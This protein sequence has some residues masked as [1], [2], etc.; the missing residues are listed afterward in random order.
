M[1]NQSNRRVLIQKP[2]LDTC[3]TALILGV[4]EKDEITVLRGRAPDSDLNDPNVYCIESGGSGQVHLNNYDHHDPKQYFPPACRQV[5]DASH[6]FSEK[7][8]RLVEY[9]CMVDERINEHHPVPFPSLSNIFSGMLFSE[10]ILLRQ[11]FAGIQILRVVIDDA[12]D[13]FGTMPDLLAWRGYRQAKEENMAKLSSV[14][15]GAFFFMSKE[16]DKVCFS[17]SDVIGGIGAL[18]NM[19]CDFV[20]LLNPSFGNPPVRKYTIAGNGRKVSHLLSYIDSR[21]PGWGGRDS[22]IGSPREGSILEKELIID[23]ARK[24]L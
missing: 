17:E 24:Y 4:S 1:L 20:I 11:F 21:E 3:L 14:K 2:D 15:E 12:I 10:S 7:I 13:P 23:L 18:Y 16:G 5:F 22:I 6:L 9:V 19:G 8:H